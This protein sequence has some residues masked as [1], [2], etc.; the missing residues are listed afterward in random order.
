MLAERAD[1]SP[2]GRER[3]DGGVRHT[4]VRAAVALL[5][6]GSAGC[7]RATPS[8]DGTPVTAS[9]AGNVTLGGV[10]LLRHPVGQGDVVPGGADRAAL[11]VDAGCVALTH[12]GDTTTAFVLW[13]EGFAL[14]EGS[15]GLEVVDEGGNLVGAVGETV[16]LAGGYTDVQRA[17]DLTGGQVPAA[18]QVLDNRY[19]YATPDVWPSSHVD[20]V[21]LLHQRGEE[22]SGDQ[23]LLSGT[24]GERDGCVAVGDAYLLWP[25][26]YS[27]RGTRERF[28][29]IA[30]DGTVVATSG[31][32]VRMGGGSGPLPDTRELPGGVPEACRASGPDGYW[33]VGALGS[34]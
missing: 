9:A 14:R 17:Q 12:G 2:G 10:T 16:E 21:T 11:A 15:A 27:L 26:G 20:G 13:P 34:P 22:L 7:V 30:P 33:L 19:F 23:A 24:L 4:R 32:P 29:V 31:R 6:L 25:R 3:H 28:E 5:L 8:D 18:C 1:R